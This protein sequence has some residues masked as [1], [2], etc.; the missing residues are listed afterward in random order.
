VRL[1]EDDAPEAQSRTGGENFD[2]SAPQIVRVFNGTRAHRGARE[3]VRLSSIPLATTRGA[4][5]SG[6]SKELMPY[7]KKTI[8]LPQEMYEAALAR[9]KRMGYDSFSE[10]VQYLIQQDLDDRPKHSLV[11]EEPP[12]FRA[13][14]SKA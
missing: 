11:R 4:G 5:S 1:Y 9:A 12:E 6:V 13:K 2:L 10:Y 7:A 14:R 3:F 8:S